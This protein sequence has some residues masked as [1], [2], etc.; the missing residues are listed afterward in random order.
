MEPQVKEEKA[1]RRRRRSKGMPRRSGEDGERVGGVAVVDVADGAE[2]M[3]GESGSSCAVA[4]VWISV[5]W[6]SR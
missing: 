2:S 5:W 6:K 3:G 4:I 1:A